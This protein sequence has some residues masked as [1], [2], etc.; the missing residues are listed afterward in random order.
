MGNYNN[1]LTGETLTSGESTSYTTPTAGKREIELQVVGDT[2]S[3]SLDINVTGKVA[4]DA[5]FGEN[6]FVDVT[7]KDLTKLLNNSEIFTVDT[8]GIN[9]IQVEIINN[10]NSSTTI[11]AYEGFPTGV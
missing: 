5:P 7:D 10:A 11:D 3:T 9:T 6:S 4:P 1:S 2:D 8:T